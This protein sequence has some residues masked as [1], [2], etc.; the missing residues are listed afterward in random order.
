MVKIFNS[1]QT[2]L[3]IGFI[4]LILSVSLLTF[5]YTFAET[6][7]AIKEIVKTELC[8]ISAL[9]EA[10]FTDLERET[11]KNLKHGDEDKPEFKALQKKL[12][13]MLTSHPDITDIYTM[14]LKGKDIVFVVDPAYGDP[15]E[16]IPAPGIDEKYEEVT[17]EMRQGFEK[18]IAESE[19]STDDW[20]TLLSGYAPIR[21]SQGNKIG[22]VGVDMYANIVIQKQDYLGKTI[23]IMIGISTLIAGLLILFFSKTIIKDI[24]KLNTVA[25]EIS[26]GN[27]EVNM[28]VNRKDEIGELS[29]SFGRMVASLK[30]M[31]MK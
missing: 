27:M 2:K 28:E 4:L 15:K 29:D 10:S 19:F 5:F 23:F 22:L 14:R 6:K 25:R 1:L 30:I 16:P 21:D 9:T 26:T 3:T 18:N 31:M 13:A 24:H 20:G 11:L 7:K 12:K 17:P 8:A